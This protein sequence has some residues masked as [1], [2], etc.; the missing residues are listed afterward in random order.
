MR[1]R[2]QSLLPA[3]EQA[4]QHSE[5]ALREL[6]ERQNRLSA[7]E[8][9]LADLRRYRGEYAQARQ[10]DG[11]TVHA[12]LNL[13]RFIERID[14]GIAQQEREVTRRRRAL[15]QAAAA[16]REAHARE[17]ALASVA[18]R[19][20]EQERRGEERREQRDLDER[21]QRRAPRDRGTSS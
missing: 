9:Q 6:G 17:R 4:R 15:E 2:A 11:M 16:W 10:A 8:R 3:I 1:S 20:S 21:A 13:Q 18:E 7:A 12:L 14:L 19:A 5:A